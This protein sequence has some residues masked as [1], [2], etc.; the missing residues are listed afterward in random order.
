MSGKDRE[1]KLNE[2]LKKNKGKLDLKTIRNNK[3]FP[4]LQRQKPQKAKKPA[5]SSSKVGSPRDERQLTSAPGFAKQSLKIQRYTDKV[6]GDGQIKHEFV[7]YKPYTAYSTEPFAPMTH[8][9]PTDSYGYTAD[10]AA[11]G[12]SAADLGY[13]NTYNGKL[14][15]MAVDEMKNK[16]KEITDEFNALLRK[17]GNDMLKTYIGQLAV[18]LTFDQF[19][20]NVEEIVIGGLP[21]RVDN[22]PVDMEAMQALV[23]GL[24]VTHKGVLIVDQI[25]INAMLTMYLNE[26]N[27]KKLRPITFLLKP[28]NDLK[29]FT[30]SLS[31][32]SSGGHKKKVIIYYLMTSLELI[33][34]IST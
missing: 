30:D 17:I 23:T 19:T 27:R 24:N 25:Y 26:F 10:Q 21:D 34:Y 20:D 15:M 7:N 4:V 16:R 9:N 1:A 32:F 22:M 28:Y 6:P 2:I 33:L 12:L 14:V 29:T 5:S 31:M 3:V 18:N 11:S 8:S 13:P